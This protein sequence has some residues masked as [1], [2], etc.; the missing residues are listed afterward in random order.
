MTSA[1]PL[2]VAAVPMAAQAPTVRLTESII[3][4]A[5]V[6]EQ[7]K[8]ESERDIRLSGGASL[9]ACEEIHHL[10]E[11]S[12]M[13]YLRPPRK[14][15]PVLQLQAF[16]ADYL[17]ALRAGEP[18]TQ[19]H[20]V[21]YFTELLQLKLR[22]RLRSPQAIEDVRQETFAR[23]L[24]TIRKKDG[25][26]QPERLGP[27]VNTVCNNVLLEH[28]RQASRSD[29]LDEEGAPELPARGGS[30]LD[31]VESKQMEAQ[32]REVLGGLPEHDRSLLKA[33]FLD[34]RDRDEVCREF[35]VD[36]DYLRVLLH[37]AKHVFKAAYVKRNGDRLPFTS[38][39]GQA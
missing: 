9:N 10:A 35:G 22:S 4:D 14:M 7:G 11:P 2:G 36:R 19:E 12:A 31:A 1:L 26:R 3:A 21:C 30:V 13:L 34:E 29:S 39:T 33:V 27:F 38:A 32:V 15:G 8:C 37:R 20:F 24:A 6:A 16:D 17:E 25:L 23:V 5:G 28:Y 18:R